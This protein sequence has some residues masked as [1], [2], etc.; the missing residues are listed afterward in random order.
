MAG[1]RRPRRKRAIG[2]AQRARAAMRKLLGSH[3]LARVAGGWMGIAPE[4]VV[5]LGEA[6]SNGYSVTKFLNRDAR[7]VR[8]NARGWAE[9]LDR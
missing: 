2:R 5:R 3:G 1:S 9:I 7:K 8:F 4:N 6:A